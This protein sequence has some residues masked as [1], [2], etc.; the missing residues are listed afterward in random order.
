MK[1]LFLTFVC[2]SAFCS[3]WA[4]RPLAVPY[5]LG[6]LDDHNGRLLAK[7][8]GAQSAQLDKFHAIESTLVSY[9][10]SL[11]ML[12]NKRTPDKIQYSFTTWEKDGCYYCKEFKLLQSKKLSEKING[13]YT[14]KPGKDEGS[15]AQGLY[16]GTLKKNLFKTPKERCSFLAG[17][18]ARYGSREEHLYKFRLTNSLSKFNA[19]LSELKALRCEVVNVDEK[20]GEPRVQQISF[21]PSEELK[22]YLDKQLRIQTDIQRRKEKFAR[23]HKPG[24]EAENLFL[25]N[26]E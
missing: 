13:S 26:E 16:V 2:V 3:A 6:L 21:I 11:L 19:I 7:E 17:A 1:K 18:F 4:Q 12:E 25:M 5:V 8:S 23:E 15:R 20:D 10:D 9:L 14:F 24:K 22:A